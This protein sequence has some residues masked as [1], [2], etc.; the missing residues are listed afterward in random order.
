M[1]ADEPLIDSTF[2][3]RF[4]APLLRIPKLPADGRVELGDAWRLESYSELDGRRSLAELRGGWCPNGLAF[5]LV[6]S[7]KRQSL[8]CRDSQVQESDGLELLVDTR[9]TKSVHRS[10]RFHHR[11]LF[12]PAGSG[13][14]GLAPTTA[15]MPVARAREH[16][17]PPPRGSLQARSEL[18][19]GGYLLDVVLRSG[20]LTG[21]DPAEHSRIGFSY[22]VRDRELGWQTYSL[23]PEY[24]FDADPSL[25]CSLDL[26]S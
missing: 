2:L 26:I 10:G 4:A 19:P 9:D 12:L 17:G 7:G 22:V 23:S 20:A 14:G 16:P 13:P 1:S 8:W 11:F 24:A 18:R 6:V 25:W 15:W 21:W 5:R 3:F